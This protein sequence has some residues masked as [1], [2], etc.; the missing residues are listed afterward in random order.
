MGF[1]NGAQEPS[2]PS[3]GAVPNTL[4]T[5]F[6]GSRFRSESLHTAPRIALS[7]E[8]TASVSVALY[9]YTWVPFAHRDR[10]RVP[11]QFLAESH[12]AVEIARRDVLRGVGGPGMAV[13][14]WP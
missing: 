10:V 13:S 9:K 5:A 11:V 1:P 2:T 8:L 12:S 4:I 3:S 14:L 6:T 7:P